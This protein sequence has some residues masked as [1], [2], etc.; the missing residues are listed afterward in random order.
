M[1]GSN[2]PTIGG[3]V[4]GFKH[5]DVWGC[6]CIQVYLTPSRAWAVPDLTDSHIAEFREAWSRSRVTEIVAH[7][8]FLVNVASSNLEVRKRAT[9]R[10][11]QEVEQAQK[12]GVK[13]L[14]LHPGSGGAL[15]RADGVSAVVAG[16]REA[17]EGF[18]KSAPKL[19]LETMA[20]QGRMVG[21]R[22]QE[23]AEILDRV[24][25]PDN[26]GVCFDT[27]HVFFAG[28][29][30]R[31]YEGYSA[32]IAEFDKIVGVEQI[33]AFHINDAKSRLGSGHDRHANIG[34]GRLGLQVFHALVRDSRFTDIPQILEI[35]DR[36]E[37]SA[38]NLALL[39][40]LRVRDD[41]L[42]T[43]CENDPEALQL[44]F[45]GL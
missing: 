19:L 22:F 25:R 21:S 27:A 44:D 38:L 20:G 5:A 6:E 1:L 31:G 10:L 43:T 15:P 7:I 45:A 18:D 17:L 16:I 13:N 42:P 39:K 30:I 14:V 12:L 37:K 33:R 24:D 11:T 23:L 2:V 29:D 36:D 32:V 40:E 4:Q 35:P 28:Y 9:A 26:L 41:T 34:E 3:L 8:P